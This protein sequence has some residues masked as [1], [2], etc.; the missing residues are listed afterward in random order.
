MPLYG[1]KQ[2]TPVTNV[3]GNNIMLD[4]GTKHLE[5]VL[6]YRQSTKLGSVYLLTV[7]IIDLMFTD[8]VG[9]IFDCNSCIE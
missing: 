2:Y 4:S 1:A 8:T 3:A 7:L 9:P 5:Y 6:F